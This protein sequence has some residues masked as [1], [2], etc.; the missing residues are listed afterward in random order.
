MSTIKLLIQTVNGVIKN[1]NPNRKNLKKYVVIGKQGRRRLYSKRPEYYEKENIPLNERRY[2]DKL[3]DEKAK[4]SKSLLERLFSERRK[5]LQEILELE[6]KEKEEEKKPPRYIRAWL[7]IKYKADQ[8][9]FIEAYIDGVEGSDSSLFSQLREMV[10][11]NFSE[12][13]SQY[14]EVGF[15]Y[16]P[17]PEQK[18]PNV[19]YKHNL[20][21]GWQTL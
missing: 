18:T 12:E 9:A 11:S 16:I 4:E 13:L 20:I 17:K 15:E 21:S 14:S 5:S 6:E 1:I 8:P 7:K 3:S 10:A 19:R 2:E